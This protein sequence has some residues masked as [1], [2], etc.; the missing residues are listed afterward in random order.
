MPHAAGH[1]KRILQYG[2]P[3]EEVGEAGHSHSQV[4]QDWLVAAMLGCKKGGYFIDLA[5]NNATDLSNTLMLERDFGW[6]GVCI[7]ANP[8]YLPG[9]MKRRCDVVMAAVGSPTD[10]EVTFRMGGVLGG[11]VGSEMDNKPQDTGHDVHLRTVALSDI[12][13]KLGAPTSIDLLSL[14]VEGAESIVMQGFPWD[15]YRFDVI[16]VERPKADLRTTMEQ[17]GYG[18]VRQNSDWGDE[19]WIN[20]K[21][22][23]ANSVLAA[24][25]DG[26]PTPTD[27]C[28]DKLG[29][30]TPATMSKKA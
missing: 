17:H 21:L 12:L 10:T 19:T 23:R 14:D 27:T 25:K 9:L 15:K 16:V 2:W 5:A 13:Q 7:D 30:K 28:M 22:P 3:E 20:L 26:A 29:M 11:V 4:G 1:W 24:F 6:D 18:H 8:V